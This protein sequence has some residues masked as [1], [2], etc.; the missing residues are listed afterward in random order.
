MNRR[1]QIVQGL[2][3]A[4]VILA[5]AIAGADP[6]FTTVLLPVLASSA[7]GPIVRPSCRLRVQTKA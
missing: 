1:L 3:W 4:A 2:I 7:F 6:F 5:A